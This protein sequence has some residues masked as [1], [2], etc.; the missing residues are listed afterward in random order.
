MS[1]RYNRK[2][3]E[4]IVAK[5]KE[6]SL[7]YAEGAKEFGIPVRR[8]YDFLHRKKKLA[9]KVTETVVIEEKPLSPSTTNP[10]ACSSLPQEVQNLI[11]EY[12]RK[13][14]GHGFKRI[15]DHL[16]SDHLLVVKRK[17]IRQVLK[18]HNLLEQ[19]DSSF[20]RKEPGAKGTRRFEAA[21]AGELYQMDVSYIYLTG[22]PV[23]Y[24]VA[25][26]DDYSRY[27][28]GAELCYDQRGETLIGVLHNACVQHG[29]PKKLL[30][31]QGS[32]F[33][34]WSEKQTI[35]QQYLD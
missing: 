28:V 27:C 4:E 12:R 29:K 5:I 22:T 17:Q 11:I 2:E 25:V 21:Y 9:S 23:L 16:K 24:L 33:Y 32:G 30:T 34:S 19:L 6:L 31:D 20:D 13:N 18:S 3:L 10:Y 8:I 7:T 1:K 35:F 14:Q 26:V 15:E